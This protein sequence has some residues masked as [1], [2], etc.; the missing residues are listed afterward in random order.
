[1]IFDLKK[2]I[3]ESPGPDSLK[4]HTNLDQFNISHFDNRNELEDTQQIVSYNPEESK[5]R[6][7]W[8]EVRKTPSKKI[9]NSN[10]LPG[11]SPTPKSRTSEQLLNMDFFTRR[12]HLDKTLSDLMG[13]KQKLVS[14]LA[15]IPS[16]GMKS[17][18]R[19]TEVEELL[20]EIDLKICATRKTM[21]NFGVL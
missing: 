3:D 7:T 20:D 11:N 10:Q 4:S 8:A 1:L 16:S 13:Q 17:R 18:L 5:S 14:E 9:I 21:K 2:Q 19:M 12:E 15:K 6:E